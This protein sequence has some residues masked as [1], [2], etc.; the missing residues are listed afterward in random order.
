MKIVISP[1]V[2]EDEST[3][4]AFFDVGSIDPEVIGV[5]P[6]RALSSVTYPA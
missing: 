3:E 2:Q 5:S 6:E 4:I 1:L